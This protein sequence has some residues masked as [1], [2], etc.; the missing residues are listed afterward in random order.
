MSLGKT[1]ERLQ[2]PES[3][4]AKLLGFRKR[5]WWIKMAEAACMAVFGIL[6]AFLVMFLLDRVWETPLW[7]RA[8][9]FAAALAGCALVPLALYRWVWR[10]RHLE[11]LARLL[12]RKLPQVGDQLLGVIELV[13]S[14]SEQ[15]RSPALCEAA[16]HQVAEDAEKRDFQA[17][18]PN[19]RHR[20]W[21]GLAAF[22][23][24]IALVLLLLFPA[25]AAN[26]WVRLLA[27][28]RNTPR[29]TF[30]A[31]EP[32][33]DKLV[34][35]HGEPFSVTAALTGKTVWRPTEGLAQLG[36]QS[37]VRAILRDGLYQFE[38]PAQID[39]GLLEVHIG[40]SV[41]RVR[42]EPTIRP[43]LTSVVALVSLPE[44]LGRPQTQKKDVRGGSITLVNG[45]R[46]TFAATASRKL[47]SAQVD[48]Q[49]QAPSGATV[50]SPAIAVS[51][52]RK[53]EFRW[54]DQ[55]GL[56]GKEPFA[57]TI[58]GCD[59]EPPSVGCDYLQHQKVVLDTE[60]L[61]FK[62]RAQDDFGVKRVGMEWQGVEDPVAKTFP[63]GERILALG[64][65]DKDS[66]EL[67]GTFSAQAL[68]I[69]PQPVVVRVFVEDYFPGRPRV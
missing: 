13:H 37:P 27:P 22:P 53:L 2:L 44:Y 42:I 9:L 59:D 56:A 58:T 67:T 16:I 20:L 19:P 1:H 34:V 15:A 62:V 65:G 54:R 47:S 66:L 7:P 17:A 32:L 4:Q 12:S 24:V 45:S 8:G 43:E 46:V 61:S 26:S 51:G 49:P 11:Q 21:S 39:P 5:V 28:W 30:A 50:H 35:A 48:G 31:L 36:G 14:D 33:P 23:G 41:Q 52:A 29:Y 25:A 18:V 57:L 40:D 6:V 10:N 60:V 63:K 55:F 38:L 3:L 69:E 68:G 64:G